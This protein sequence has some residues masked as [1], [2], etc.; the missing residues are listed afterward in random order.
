MA[1][2]VRS[3]IT[4][5]KAG[6]GADLRMFIEKRLLLTLN[7][8]RKVVG[9][10]RGYDMFMNLVIDNCTELRKNNVKVPMGTAVIRGNAVCSWE[11][12]DNLKLA[13]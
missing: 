6:P 3:N 9:Q 13:V 8:K 7:N 12:L 4:Y 5:G 10:L 1:P 11:C 2:G